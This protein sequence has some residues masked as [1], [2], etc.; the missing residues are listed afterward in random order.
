MIYVNPSNSNDLL[1]YISTYAWLRMITSILDSKNIS[2]R[3]LQYSNIYIYICIYIYI[4]I[5]PDSK[6]FNISQNISTLNPIFQ[7]LRH[8]FR[9][10]RPH[11]DQRSRTCFHAL[12][13]EVTNLCPANV[14][15]RTGENGRTWAMN[16]WGW[17]KT[18]VPSEP[19]NSW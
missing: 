7:P 5:I 3:L 8:V 13:G 16:I 1:Q 18:L 12:L 2:S 19:Q 11:L 15:G 10:D 6:Y 17:V 9:Y 4:S 14:E